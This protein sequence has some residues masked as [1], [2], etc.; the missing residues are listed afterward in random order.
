MNYPDF[1]RAFPALDVPFSEDVV[2]THA[3]RSDAGLVV[4]FEF[5]EDFDLPAHAHK[6]QWGTVMAGEIEL[7]IGGE[8]RSYRPGDSYNI[9]AGVGHSARVRAGTRVVDAFEEPD[10]YPIRV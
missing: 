1:I 2:R 9:P 8:T 3:I 10:R 4:F 5:L 6:G 7:T